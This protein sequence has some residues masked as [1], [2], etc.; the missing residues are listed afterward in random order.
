MT[1]MKYGASGALNNLYGEI[2]HV[3]TVTAEWYTPFLDLGDNAQTKTLTGMTV[4]TEPGHSGRVSFGYETR[5]VT[6]LA[7]QTVGM[8]GLDLTALSFNEFSLSAF[9]G[10]W[11]VRLNERNINYIAFRWLSEEPSDCRVDSLNARYTFTGGI[12][13]GL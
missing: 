10:S 3:D 1:M 2:V 11:S 5:D 8:G 6:R 12:R 9:A 13:G 4:A 7:A